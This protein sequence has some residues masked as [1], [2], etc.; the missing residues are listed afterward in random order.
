MEILNIGPLELVFILLIALIVLGP[1]DMIKTGRSIAK[2]ISKFIRSPVWKSMV[3]TS[4]EIRDLPRKFIREAG[5]EESVEEITRLNRFPEENLKTYPRVVPKEEEPSKQSALREE[6]AE[7]AV[8][9][10]EP[11]EQ[12]DQAEERNPE[13]KKD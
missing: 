8:P 5:I 1:D 11:V 13:K 10:E 3:T 6:P 4:Q 2:G 9:Q 7:H 12:S